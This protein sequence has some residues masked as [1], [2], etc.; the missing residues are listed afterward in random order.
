M[1]WQGVQ[2][3]FPN[4]LVKFEIF[5]SEGINHKEFIDDFSESRHVK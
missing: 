3:I 2:Q 5:C 1:K 4:Q